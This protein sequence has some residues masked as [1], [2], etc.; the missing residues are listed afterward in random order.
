[1]P[2]TSP[3][4]NEPLPVPN[5]F[6]ALNNVVFNSPDVYG[7]IYNVSVIWNILSIISFLVSGVFI[8]AYIYAMQRAAQLSDQE[9]AWLR[10]QE[11]K[12]QELYLGARTKN[13]RWDDVETHIASANPSD[14]RLAIIEADIMLEEAFAEL[15][16][17]G[18]TLGE[19]LKSA[20]PAQIRSLDD[21]WR[22][23]KVRNEIAHAGADFVLTKALADQTIAQ[24][25]R[26]FIELGKI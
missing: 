2:E 21:A 12:Y 9:N 16:L 25:K 17:A 6:D 24:F 8:F 20:S 11:K 1:M 3:L 10:G 13:S 5:A 18:N 26:V 23:H 14:W 4:S 22:A 19:R 7:I 15:G